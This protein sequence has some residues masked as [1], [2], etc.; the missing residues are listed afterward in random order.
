MFGQNEFME[1]GF[2]KRLTE[3]REKK[4]VSAREMSISLGQSESYINNIEN[5]RNFP[6]M[7]IFFYICDYLGVT[8]KE[9]FDTEAND[10]GRI[11][12]V[13]EKMKQLSDEQLD[14]IEAMIDN[15]NK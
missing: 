14:L 11:K 4:N 8:P 13:T 7:A 1:S 15:M 6:K 3:L 10:P 2:Y 12:T 5:G 9:F